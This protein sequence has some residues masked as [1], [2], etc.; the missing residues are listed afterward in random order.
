MRDV[1]FALAGITRRAPREM[2]VHGGAVVLRVAPL[3]LELISQE[4]IA[5]RGVDEVAGLPCSLRPSSV[6]R[7]RRAAPRP[8]VQER[9]LARAAALDDLRACAA[10]LRIRISSN[11]ERRT[12]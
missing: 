1:A 8:S 3:A 12:W 5:A 9:D 7:T 2:R 6:L 11:S 10:A 4:R